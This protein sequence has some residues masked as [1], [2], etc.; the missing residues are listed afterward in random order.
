MKGWYNVPENNGFKSLVYIVL[1]SHAQEEYM[2]EVPEKNPVLASAEKLSKAIELAS[3]DPANYEKEFFSTLLESL[4]LVPIAEP[5]QPDY[6]EEIAQN[7]MQLEVISG[8][9]SAGEPVHVL[10]S[11][12]DALHAWAQ[13]QCNYVALPTPVA[14]R[15]LVESE[16][17]VIL[18]PAGPVR[19]S[20]AHFMIEAFA[21]GQVPE[22]LQE[23]TLQGNSETKYR[24]PGDDVVDLKIALR[25]ALQQQEVERAFL[26]EVKEGES[27]RLLLVLEPRSSANFDE[28]ARGLAP[29]LRSSAQKGFIIEVAPLRGGLAAMCMQTTD[30][31]YVRI[32]H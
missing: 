32:E 29:M 9:N 6:I 16:Y 11:S 8:K 30:P 7:G 20:F 3:Q 17:Q 28:L 23:I 31:F 24:E 27:E 21:K 14:F 4:L 12:P 10:F 19:Y 22:V 18:D 13:K 25:G 2:P 5:V 15:N 26:I 1:D